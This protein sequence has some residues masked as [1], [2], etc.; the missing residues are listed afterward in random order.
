MIY[1]K[2]FISVFFIL[3]IVSVVNISYIE[4]DAGIE[5]LYLDNTFEY[6]KSYYHN[7]TNFT[8]INMD[9][10]LSEEDVINC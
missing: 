7:T 9:P 3:S 6:Y 1:N 8:I 2:R 4:H 10:T 5:R